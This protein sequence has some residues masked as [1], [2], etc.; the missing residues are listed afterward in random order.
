MSRIIEITTK[1]TYTANFQTQYTL[2]ELNTH[3]IKYA[4]YDCV[5]LRGNAFIEKIYLFKAKI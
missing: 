5:H 2:I 1:E 4:Q 3:K